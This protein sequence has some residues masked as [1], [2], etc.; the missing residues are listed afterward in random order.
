MPDALMR[1]FPGGQVAAV[2]GGAESRQA[3]GDGNPRGEDAVARFTMYGGSRTR[4]SHREESTQKRDPHATETE[5][6]ERG[7]RV[8]VSLAHTDEHVTG[9]TSETLMLHRLM[10]RRRQLVQSTIQSQ[11]VLLFNNRVALFAAGNGSVRKSDQ[12]RHAACPKLHSQQYAG[13]Q[14]RSRHRWSRTTVK[15]W[16]CIKHGHSCNQCTCQHRQD[17][18]DT[19]KPASR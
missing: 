15:R 13:R 3:E 5:Q 4:V 1:S 12:C 10:R 14:C 11:Q 9:R 17:C 16:P 18:G 6:Q 19:N 8:S 7:R 2:R